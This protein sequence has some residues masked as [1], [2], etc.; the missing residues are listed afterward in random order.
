MRYRKL[1]RTDLEISAISFGAMALGGRSFAASE[2][3]RMRAVHAALDAG[4]NAIDT[5]PLYEF[6][7]SEKMLRRA[8]Q[9]RRALGDVPLASI[10]PELNLIER[11]AEREIL[12]WAREHGAGVLSYSPLYKGLLSGRVSDSRE[13]AGDDFRSGM[14]AFQPANRRRINEALS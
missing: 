12:P 2:E 6:G 14:A 13:L 3:S 5:A 1:G 7:G 4:I 8:L 10:Q 11:S 9:G